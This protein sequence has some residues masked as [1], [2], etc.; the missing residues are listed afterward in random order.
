MPALLW[1]KAAFLSALA[2]PDRRTERVACRKRGFG[3]KCLG[4]VE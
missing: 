4:G 2:M 1:V 3:C